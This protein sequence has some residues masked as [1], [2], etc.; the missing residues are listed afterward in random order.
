MGGHHGL[1]EE[2]A[3]VI[4]W[5]G[6]WAPVWVAHLVGCAMPVSCGRPDASW[7]PRAASEKCLRV[8]PQVQLFLPL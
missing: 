6:G 7:Q 8:F 1:H 2:L 4:G 3:G 5:Q